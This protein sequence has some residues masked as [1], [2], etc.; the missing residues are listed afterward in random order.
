MV[1]K[2]GGVHKVKIAYSIYEGEIIHVVYA[3]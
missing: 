2:K 1:Q 3:F